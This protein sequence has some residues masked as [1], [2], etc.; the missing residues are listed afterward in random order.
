MCPKGGKYIYVTRN[1]HDTANSFYH[2]FGDWVFKKENISI[3]YFVEHFWLQR[4]VP[5]FDSKN[6]SYFHHLISY[7]FKRRDKDVL[8]LHYE[9]LVENMR[10]C[11]ILIAEFMNI[12]TSDVDLINLVEKQVF[13]TFKL[14]LV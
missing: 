10:K 3:D 14:K 13:S 6:A 5:G 4:G 8:W 1:P 2:F 12:D 7:Y 9:D 11:I